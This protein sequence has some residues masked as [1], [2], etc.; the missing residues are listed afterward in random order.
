[1]GKHHGS[2]GRPGVIRQTRRLT[3]LL[4]QP[5]KLWITAAK[6]HLPDGKTPWQW[7]AERRASSTKPEAV[8]VVAALAVVAVVAEV[9]IV[10]V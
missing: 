8:A 10:A 2:E 3:S 4:D 6:T 1:M 9:A 5:D 7:S